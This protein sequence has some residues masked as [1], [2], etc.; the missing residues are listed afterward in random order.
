MNAAKKQILADQI[1][2]Q[3]FEIGRSKRYHAHRMAWHHRIAFLFQFI[4][5]SAT[6]SVLLGLIGERFQ[7]YI[8]G[9]GAIVTGLSLGHLSG[10]YLQWHAAK[11]EAFGELMKIIPDNEEEATPDLLHRIV[12]RREEIEK[13][14]DVGFRCLDMVCYNE[15]CRA[16]GLYDRMVHL[17]LWQRYVGTIFP[18]DYNYDYQRQKTS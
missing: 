15:E 2:E 10:K 13:D 12:V 17:S 7:P 5:L 6:S 16:R 4:E 9:L 14:D 1:W 11:K 3:K 18:L 8:L